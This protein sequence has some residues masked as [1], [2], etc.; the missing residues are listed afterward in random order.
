MSKLLK[1]ALKSAILPCSLLVTGKF[2]SVFLLISVLGIDFSVTNEIQALFSIQLNIMD[3]NTAIYINSLSNFICLLLIA[4]PT[5][6]IF[7]RNTL[8][9]DAQNN[10]KVVVKLSKLNVLKWVTGPE[11]TLIKVIVWSIFLWIIS[12]IC[13]S[14]AISNNI[15]LWIG[16]VAG[17]L[18]L[19]SAFGILRTFDKETA[20]IYPEDN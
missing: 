14:Q 2:L 12:G 3:P 16:I 10:P 13:I 5:F 19:L 20:K 11:N 18:S 9:K 1:R 17:V 15:Y 6:I 7:F 4:I 8:L